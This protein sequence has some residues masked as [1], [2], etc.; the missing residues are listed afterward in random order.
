[1]CNSLGCKRWLEIDY[2]LF[3]FFNKLLMLGFDLET[4]C[5]DTMLN[6]RK[7]IPS[8]DCIHIYIEVYN[9]MDYMASML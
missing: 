5:F 2:N 7:A 6:L 8:W 1:M 9:K 4:S 3:L